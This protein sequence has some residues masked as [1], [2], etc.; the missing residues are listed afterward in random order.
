MSTFVAFLDGGETNDAGIARAS[1][2]LFTNDGVLGDADLEP[3]E[4]DTPD[5]TVKV[6]AGDIVIG[7][8][9]PTANQQ[10][11]MYR[12][13]LDAATTVTIAANASGNPR[14][15]IVVAYVDT[16]AF[17]TPNNQG[18]LK[19]ADVQGTPAATPVEPTDANIVTALGAGVPF[20]RIAKVAVANGFAT[21]VDAN[22]TDQ[23]PKTSTP[24]RFLADI[25]DN[26]VATGFTFAT[27]ASLVSAFTGGRAYVGGR[28]ITKP[29][30]NHTFTASKDTYVDVSSADL[31]TSNDDLTY[32]AVANG[33]GEPSLA[34]GQM[35]IAK[36]V[37][38]GT[39][40]TTVTDLRRLSPG[41][42]HYKRQLITTDST[43]TDIQ[44]QFGVT[45]T[46]Y[47]G[48]S[49]MSTEKTITLPEPFDD[50]NYTVVAICG[51]RSSGSDPTGPSDTDGRGTANVDVRVLSASQFSI[52]T[53]DLVANVANT[54]RDVVHW[55]A[56]GK[57]RT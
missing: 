54:E 22:I 34:A 27:S 45:F 47:P 19:F 31:P 11:E 56:K 37:T 32:T 42:Q 44:E 53:R 49:Q 24:E 51:G 43:Q 6:A 38:D 5:N 26:F 20:V 40:V 30:Y 36:V 55:I 17:G 7:Y 35:R 23:R 15:D 8:D 2:P 52:Q 12:G 18:A 48:G 21:I 33:A 46:A 9:S 41:K 25:A 1:A 4:N 16:T 29:N 39:A 13:W 57:R 50:A 14:I 28:V 10:R 3:T